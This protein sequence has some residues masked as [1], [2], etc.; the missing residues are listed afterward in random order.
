[1]GPYV[2]AAGL[3]QQLGFGFAHNG[4]ASSRFGRS[5]DDPFSA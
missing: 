4:S 3:I 1:M 5:T 2:N